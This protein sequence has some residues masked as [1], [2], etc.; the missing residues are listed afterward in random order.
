MK[1]RNHLFHRTFSF[2]DKLEKLE[3]LSSKDIYD[4]DF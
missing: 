4:L 2:L 1:K 3:K